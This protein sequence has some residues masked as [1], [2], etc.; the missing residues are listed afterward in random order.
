ML[1][2]LET[3]QCILGCPFDPQCY[4]NY[5]QLCGYGVFLQ[6]VIKDVRA[7]YL[8]VPSELPVIQEEH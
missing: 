6:V 1:T 2:L 8:S 3:G 5:Q 4:I 7:L